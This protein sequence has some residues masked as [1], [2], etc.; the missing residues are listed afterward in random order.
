M[1]Q[2]RSLVILL[3]EDDPG[4]AALAKRALKSWSHPLQIH[5][6]LDGMECLQFLRREGDKF[7]DAPRPDMILLDLN[8][9]RLDGREV[10][11]ALQSDPA[12]ANIPV[13]VLTTSDFE[14]DILRSYES[15]ANSFITKP[16]EF[17]QFVSMMKALENYWCN[18]VSLPS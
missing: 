5:H 14:Q 17:D 9:P 10:L 12:L 11:Q 13:V 2:H 18:V 4:D 15:G 16:V 8:M 1:D 6:V 7:A 3:V